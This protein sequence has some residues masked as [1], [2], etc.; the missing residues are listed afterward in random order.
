MYPMLFLFLTTIVNAYATRCTRKNN[1]QIEKHD[2]NNDDNKDD[3][4]DDLVF[5]VMY[6]DIANTVQE[7]EK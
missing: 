7:R 3:D 6:T 5:E 2:E 4:E 1:R